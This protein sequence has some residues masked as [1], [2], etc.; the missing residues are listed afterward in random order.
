M[1]EKE[2]TNSYPSPQYLSEKKEMARANPAD[3]HS[4]SQPWKEK[5]LFWG[6]TIFTGVSLATVE[7]HLL[8]WNAEREE[9]SNQQAQRHLQKYTLQPHRIWGFFPFL[10]NFIMLRCGVVR[11]SWWI[12]KTIA[13]FPSWVC[14]TKRK[15]PGF[16]QVKLKSSESLAF[17]FAI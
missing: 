15:L 5:K 10:R 6:K 3:W 9:S 4:S 17:A 13:D 2:K 11:S 12:Q 16:I 14:V 1:M 7:S 8:S